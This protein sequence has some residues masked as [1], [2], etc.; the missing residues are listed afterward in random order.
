MPRKIA[1]AKSRTSNPRRNSKPARK[2]N[3][4]KIKPAN[5]YLTESHPE[6]LPATPIK[7]DYRL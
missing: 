2:L 4:K 6:L 5:T 1:K 7:A 3:K